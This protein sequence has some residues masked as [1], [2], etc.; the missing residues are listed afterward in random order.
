MH[1]GEDDSLTRD[2]IDAPLTEIRKRG[3]YIMP[4]GTVMGVMS[5]T[6]ETQDKQET[7]HIMGGSIRWQP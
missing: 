4:D 7:G 2:P 5:A 6:E 3:D 1:A